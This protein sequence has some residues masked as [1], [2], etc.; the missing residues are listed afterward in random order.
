MALAHEDVELVAASPSSWPVA[1]R[2]ES[3]VGHW[4]LLLPLLHGQVQSSARHERRLAPL[5]PE[6]VLS[7][8][9][10]ERTLVPLLP[11]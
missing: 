7:S 5:L 6:Q 8:V 10:D 2:V 4:M 9:C 11:G 3:L 1:G